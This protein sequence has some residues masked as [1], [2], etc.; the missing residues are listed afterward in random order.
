MPGGRE[1]G[2]CITMTFDLDTAT[3]SVADVAREHALG[4]DASGSFPTE[5]VAAARNAGLLGLTTDSSNGGQGGSL[6]GAGTV[7]ERVA[8]ECGSSA[9]VLTMHYAGM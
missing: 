6:G 4:V 9:M 3:E 2:Y 1:S 5:T 7:I 8:R